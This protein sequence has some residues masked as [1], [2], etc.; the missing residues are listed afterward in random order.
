MSHLFRELLQ[1]VGSGAHTNKA[2]TR[3]E[4]ATALELMWTQQATPAQIGAFLIAHRIRRPTSEELAGMLDTYKRFGPQ[5]APIAADYPVLVFGVPYDGR[6]RTAPL[7]PLTALVLAAAGCPVVQHGAE[8]M[9]TKYGLSLVAVWDLL[10]VNW[11]DRS[12]AEIQQILQ[13]TGIGFVYVPR[14]FPLATTLTPYREQIGKRPPLATLELMWSPYGGDSRLVMGYVH[15]PTEGLIRGALD[16]HQTPHYLLV[17][18]LEGS[19]DLPRDRTAIIGS[20]RNTTAGSVS[21]RILV[22]ARDQGLSGTDVPLNRETL[23]AEMMQII[24]GN[25]TS[26]LARSIVW[27]GGFYLWQ[28]GAAVDLQAGM[29][30]A[31]ILLQTGQVQKQL[32]KLLR[33]L[34]H[35]T[36]VSGSP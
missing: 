21:D 22:A 25:I 33:S 5:L 12:L 29:A 11:R 20:Y 18:G 7:A 16:L 2:L 8:M 27:N 15:P 36:T 6:S 4:A 24:G 17:K 35:S 9:P 13:T 3:E 28:A 10:G 23:G 32:Q 30:Q 1:K 19:L 26:E 14:L 34:E 31:E